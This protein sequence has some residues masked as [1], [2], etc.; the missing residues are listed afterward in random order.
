MQ[1]DSR[2]ESDCFKVPKIKK[3]VQY[4]GAGRFAKRNCSKVPKSKT[5]MQYFDA[6]RFAKKSDCFKDQKSKK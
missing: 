1:E 5:N 3:I 4:F 6:E 2:S